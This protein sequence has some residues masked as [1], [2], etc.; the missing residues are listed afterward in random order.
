MF[1]NWMFN[2]VSPQELL[3]KGTFVKVEFDG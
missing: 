2:P 3:L 1:K